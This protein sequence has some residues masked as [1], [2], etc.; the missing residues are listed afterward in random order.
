MSCLEESPRVCRWPH[1]CSRRQQQLE[2]REES[3]VG[4]PP[5][6]VSQEDGRPFESRSRSRNSDHLLPC[7]LL[8]S[9]AIEVA[10]ATLFLPLTGF[11]SSDSPSLSHQL[12]QRVDVW[13]LL[14]KRELKS[15]LLEANNHQS[16]RLSLVLQRRSSSFCD[17]RLASAHVNPEKEDEPL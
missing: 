3:R 14:G 4:E 17:Q 13:L 12:R 1:A 15:A 9:R 7:L 8:S 16:S 11:S 2:E 6:R 10:R 5:T